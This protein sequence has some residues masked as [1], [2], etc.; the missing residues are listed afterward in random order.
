MKHLLHGLHVTYANLNKGNRLPNSRLFAKVKIIEIENFLRYA[1][2]V[3]KVLYITNTN[4]NT[5]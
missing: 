5:N 4:T 1:S 3:V 2:L